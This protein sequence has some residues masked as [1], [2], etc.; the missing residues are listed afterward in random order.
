MGVQQRQ[1]SAG[2]FSAAAAGDGRGW[3]VTAGELTDEAGAGL[4]DTLASVTDRLA[5]G[6]FG[7]LESA[8][9]VDLLETLER[10][11][12][13]MSGIGYELIARLREHDARTAPGRGSLRDL[14]ID[15]LRISGAD[16]RGRIRTAEDLAP[17]VAMTGQRLP[18]RREATGSARRDGGIGAEHARIIVAF[19][20]HLPADVDP[21][22]RCE[23]EAQ[24]VAL[25]R[26]S[27]PEHVRA[28]AE[29][30][31]GYLDP[32]GSDSSERVRRRKVFFQMQAPGPDGL[33]TGRFC[34]DAELRSYFEALFAVY[35]KPG[36]CNPDD[37]AGESGT[38][39]NNPAAGDGTV[40]DEPDGSGSPDEH[41]A[42]GVATGVDHHDGSA[43]GGD[44]AGSAAGDD[45]EFS[46]ADDDADD[47]AGAAT[48]A[49]HFA[50][51]DPGTD[52]EHG[53]DPQAGANT[54]RDAP[55]G[56]GS[57]DEPVPAWQRDLRSQG[58][59]NADAVKAAL[60]AI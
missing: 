46:D 20:A 3:V 57:G 17:R 1:E 4:A 8:V 23:A 34:V 24:L 21:A 39:G 48:P 15:R 41:D 29:R 6:D 26:R 13:A 2:G 27:R 36:R 60:R 51:T 44:A 43:A 7:Q 55:T 49:G 52:T 50:A 45:A 58:Q 31:R 10:C 11:R 25:A 14:L 38:T 28:A 40:G 30:L 22:T 54:A 42:D 32:D 5:T 37:P 47:D 19:L 59:R 33:S 18:A 35:A 16:A 12:R 53:A 56:A 9:L